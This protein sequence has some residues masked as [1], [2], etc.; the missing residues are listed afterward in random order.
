MNVYTA[1]QDFSLPTLCSAVHIGDTVGKILSRTTTVVDGVENT[2]LAFFQWVGSLASAP[3]LVYTGVVPDPPVPGSASGVGGFKTIDDGADVVV[4]EVEF[5]FT[6]SSIVVTVVKPNG[7]D[8]NIFG[9][10]RQDSISPSGFTVDF[11]SPI[12]GVGY[13]LAYYAAR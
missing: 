1:I 13:S 3:Y 10:I 7:S 9:T 11:S 6:P 8:S 2:N 5:G 12:T 4:V